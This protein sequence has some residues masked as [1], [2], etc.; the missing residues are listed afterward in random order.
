M[1]L[2]KDFTDVYGRTSNCHVPD[3]TEN[4]TENEATGDVCCNLKFLSYVSNTEYEAGCKP[5][6]CFRD[7]TVCVT[8][9]EL[10]SAEGNTMWQKLRNAFVLKAME[11]VI[12]SRPTGEVDENGDPIMEDVETNIYTG[13]SGEIGYQDAVIVQ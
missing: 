7:G 13:N 5:V 2:Q 8:Q 9:A 1:Y 3:A 6:D 10:M 11:S 4:L 12:E